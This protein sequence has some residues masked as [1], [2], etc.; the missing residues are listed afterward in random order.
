MRGR[1]TERKSYV[2][3]FE[4]GKALEGPRK[5]FQ[6]VTK[7]VSEFGL[8]TIR[9]IYAVKIRAPLLQARLETAV[10]SR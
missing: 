1:V 2:P 9:L 3:P 4:L 7:S 6:I 10:L 8:L 5:L